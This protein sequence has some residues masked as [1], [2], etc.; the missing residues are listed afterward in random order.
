MQKVFS[1]QIDFTPISQ[2][3]R[4]CTQLFGEIFYFLLLWQKLCKHEKTSIATTMPVGPHFLNSRLSTKFFCRKAFYVIK[5]KE[6]RA[7]LICFRG[8]A[9]NK[10]P[11]FYAVIFCSGKA[12]NVGK[13]RLFNAA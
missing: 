13:A 4:F 1:F 10:V 9:S 8:Q 6:K 5:T 2:T 3:T 7:T 11:K 12:K